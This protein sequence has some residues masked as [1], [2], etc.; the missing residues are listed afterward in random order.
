MTDTSNPQTLCQDCFVAYL[1]ILGFREHVAWATEGEEAERKTEASIKLLDAVLEA[2]SKL[3]N[4]EDD[5]P[6]FGGYRGRI[7]S[8]TICISVPAQPGRSLHM[9]ALLANSITQLTTY[10]Y[11][12]RGALVRD[13]HFDNGRII[14]SPALIRGYDIERTQSIYPRVLLSSEVAADYAAHVAEWSPDDFATHCSVWRDWDGR[15]FV[16]YLRCFFDEEN[17]EPGGGKAFLALHRQKTLEALYT[18][19]EVPHIMSKYA[20]VSGYHNRFCRRVLPDDEIEQYLV[21]YNPEQ[22]P[23]MPVRK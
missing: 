5:H 21:P 10:G 6:L 14:F 7:F 23:W 13:S 20:W 4:W 11:F 15:L 12:V 9:L 1:D 17:G 22:E 19:R 16:N 3:W 18:H 8:D 2:A